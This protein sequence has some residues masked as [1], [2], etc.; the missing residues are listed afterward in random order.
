MKESSTMATTKSKLWYKIVI[1]VLSRVHEIPKKIRRNRGGK[2]SN[3]DALLEKQH[4]FSLMRILT[5]VDNMSLKY[6][7]VSS[8]SAS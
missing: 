4:R 5:P 1:T 3:K 8:I 6:E 7:R 2:G